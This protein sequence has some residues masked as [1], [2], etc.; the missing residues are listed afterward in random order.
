[1]KHLQFIIKNIIFLK[2]HHKK[3]HSYEINDIFAIIF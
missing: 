2:K 3:I 1:M